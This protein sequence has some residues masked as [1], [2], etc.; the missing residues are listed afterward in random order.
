[1]ND[2]KG[3]EWWDRFNKVPTFSFM[4][5]D[6]GGV[7][8]VRDSVGSWVDKGS[9]GYVVD[10]AQAEI[11]ILS[12]QR[13]ELLAALEFY[14]KSWDGGEVEWFKNAYAVEEK[15]RAAIAKAKSN[16]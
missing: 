7:V 13:D 2:R 8:S 16:D 4:A 3:Y 10:D 11:N 15:C 14:M 9:V 5:N 12:A 1:M 6:A